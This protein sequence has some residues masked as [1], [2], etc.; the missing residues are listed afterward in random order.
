MTVFKLQWL[1]VLFRLMYDAPLRFVNLPAASKRYLTWPKPPGSVR[2][3]H[4]VHQRP[5]KD[6]RVVGSDTAFSV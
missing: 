4:F 3:G 6:V 1:R 2:A 5:E